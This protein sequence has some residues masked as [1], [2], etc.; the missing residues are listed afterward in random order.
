MRRVLVSGL[1][2]QDPC[3][4]LGGGEGELGSRW[5]KPS[6]DESPFVEVVFYEGDYDSSTPILYRLHCYIQISDFDQVIKLWT[7]SYVHAYRQS[8]VLP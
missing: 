4:W 5:Q 2:N 7:L 3:F 8:H 1:P 6:L